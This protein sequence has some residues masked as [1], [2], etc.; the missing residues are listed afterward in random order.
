MLQDRGAVLT[1]VGIGAGLMYFL[2]PERG[3]R[4]R[5][6]ARDQ[7]AHT[8]RLTR[9]AAG[10]TG[11]DM[12]QRTSGTVASLRSTWRRRPVDD[13]V[14]VERVRARLGRVVS[15]PHAIDVFAADGVVTLRGP[16]LQHEVKPLLNAVDRVSGVCEVI[17]ELE[18]HKEP[19]NI[20]SLQGGSTPSEPQPDILQRNWSPTTRVIA[21]SSGLA[22][23]GY[24]ASRRTLPGALL[25]AAGVGL[26][27]RAATNLDTRRLTGIGAKRRGVDIQKTITM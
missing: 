10:A 21:G 17:S 1:G 26:L 5:A 14:L 22:L 15:H 18:E 27:T 25:A 23:A 3:R 12:A 16:I 7:V 20:P 11:R 2:D 13:D 24:G 19:G 9:D 8:A 4:R 6:L